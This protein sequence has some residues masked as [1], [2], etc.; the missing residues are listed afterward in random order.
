MRINNDFKT[1]LVIVIIP[2]GMIINGNRRKILINL[3]ELSVQASVLD[4]FGDV[5]RLYRLPVVEVSN[6]A[7]DL[8][9]AV[10]RSSG[11]AEPFHGM[12]Q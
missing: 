1:I 5:W 12:F 3:D 6:G 9:D 2:Y 4:S 11:K 10:I 8:D 7:G